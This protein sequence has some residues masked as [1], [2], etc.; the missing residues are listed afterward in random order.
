MMRGVALAGVLV[1][2]VAAACTLLTSAA[3]RSTAAGDVGWLG[4]GNTANEN[5]HT[6]PVDFDSSSRTY[7]VRL[8]TPVPQ[9]LTTSARFPLQLT[10]YHLASMSLTC[11]N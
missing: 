9:C 4:F 8:P 11:S 6:S 10:C 5:R 7:W 3:A 2:T 1:L